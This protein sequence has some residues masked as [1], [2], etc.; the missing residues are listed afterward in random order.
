MNTLY[1]RFIKKTP[2]YP[3]SYRTTI[4]DRFSRIGGGTEEEKFERGKFFANYYECYLYAAFLGIQQNYKIE[5]INRA[6]DGQKFLEIEYWKYTELVQY[7]FLSLL[8]LK[9]KELI[10]YDELEEEQLDNAA[11]ELVYLLEAYAN[12]GFDLIN[13]KLLEDPNYFDNTF[14]AITFLKE[15]HEALINKS[16]KLTQK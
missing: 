6:Q 1:D 10:S 8:V 2:F 4:L 16:E 7:L 13:S 14:S 5:L 12:G 9:N 3:K 11:L 15:M